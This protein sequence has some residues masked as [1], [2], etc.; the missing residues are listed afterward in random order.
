MNEKMAV[1]DNLKRAKEDA[2]MN[3]KE[4]TLKKM[5]IDNAD[6]TLWTLWQEIK[7]ATDAAN[8]SM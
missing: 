1:I 7:K 2:E 4:K 8:V 5:R 3:E 6:R